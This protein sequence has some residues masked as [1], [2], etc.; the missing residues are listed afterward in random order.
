MINQILP[1]KKEISIREEKNGT[2]SV[3]GL[4]E[5]TVNSVEEMAGCLDMGSSQRVTACTLMNSSSSRSH[6]IFTISIE[7][8]L[9]EDLMGAAD[10]ASGKKDEK[11]DEYM[12][13]KFHFV[14]LAGSERAKSTGATGDTFKEGV[15]INK[16]LLA[17]GN[18]IASLTD[19]TKNGHV[20]YRDSKLT[21]ILQDSLGGNSRTVM[22]AACSPAETNFNETLNTLKYA[23]RAR[24]IKN[25]P[26]V[27]RDPASQQ[28]AQLRQ[29]VYELQKELL[30]TRKVLLH[31]DIHFE[32]KIELPDA[33]QLEKMGSAIESANKT[34]GILMPT[35]HAGGSS[36]ANQAEVK[37]LEQQV[38]ELK[39]QFASKDKELKGH[40]KSYETLQ[41]QHQQMQIAQ[42]DLQKDRDYQRYSLEE[43]VKVLKKRNLFEDIVKEINGGVLPKQSEDGVKIFDTVFGNAGPTVLEEYQRKV[44]ETTREI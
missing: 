4:K 33:D 12:M 22:I 39:A 44:D 3:Y 38:Q 17:L 25:K 20:P 35:G 5:M 34:M 11:P 42:F 27:N 28:I 43:L 21:R 23:S 36:G 15:N 2:I 8:H 13:A 16:G 40:M 6:G 31:N 19:Q 41:D 29:M 10:Q 1:Q 7:Q 24:N 14:D 26:V 9:I 18:V 37:R 30:N 32:Q